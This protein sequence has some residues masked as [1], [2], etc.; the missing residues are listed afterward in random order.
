MFYQ[1]IRFIGV[2]LVLCVP[3]GFASEK[4]NYYDVLEISE[5]ASPAEIKKAHRKLVMLYHPDLNAGDKVSE[6]KF[7]RVQE[8]YDILSD[9]KKRAG[10]DNFRPKTAQAEGSFEVE[11]F[12]TKEFLDINQQLK[13]QAVAVLSH[14]LS[15]GEIA[16]KDFV[17]AWD[18]PKEKEVRT[19]FPYYDSET[20]IKEWE[21]LTRKSPKAFEALLFVY[22]N[23]SVDKQ[24][25][26][27]GVKQY[28]LAELVKHGFKPKYEGLFL[29]VVDDVLSNSSRHEF[30]LDLVVSGLFSTPAIRKQIFAR[31]AE[32][33]LAQ[34]TPAHA[35]A[36]KALYD[37]IGWL[38]SRFPD[39]L[40]QIV[41]AYQRI[42]THFVET[43]Y[44]LDS[45]VA[46]D[47]SDIFRGPILIRSHHVDYRE[48]VAEIFWNIRKLARSGFGKVVIDFAQKGDDVRLVLL[49]WFSDP[50]QDA[51]DQQHLLKLLN[52]AA[53][54]ARDPSKYFLQT[55]VIGLRE[56]AADLETLP[57][58]TWDKKS[59]ALLRAF[60]KKVST[61]V[62]DS[63]PDQ[64][65]CQRL[66]E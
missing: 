14:F 41:S 29:K 30:E 9:P 39:Q 40:Q 37:N 48:Q 4:N 60:V 33:A 42:I 36:W 28:A 54:R 55:D 38:G 63:D 56:I 18:N 12:V 49:K 5:T 17:K 22:K 11:D 23:A 43:G 53:V 25:N 10:Y 21:K 31:Y 6:E 61:L 44:S 34:L 15:L 16:K 35:I 27:I 24:S 66:L 32:K 19:K 8:A 50:E 2:L 45:V 58:K 59:K 47:P 51:K 26:G 64:L 1:Y 7:K 20:I 65:D 62:D 52:N 13:A 3:L 46:A 57:K